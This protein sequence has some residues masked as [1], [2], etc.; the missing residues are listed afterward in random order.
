MTELYRPHWVVGDKKIYNQ[1]SANQLAF[2]DNGPAYKFCWLDDVYAKQSW[3]QEPTESW[4]EL[5]VER[6]RAIRQKWKK[7][8]LFFSA[9]RDSGHA[10][11]VF[12]QAGITIDELVL[13][14]SPHHP[15][16]LHEHNNIVLPIAKELCRRNPGMTIREIRQ[17]QAWYDRLWAKS[18]WFDSRATQR[19][20]LFTSY[21]WNELIETDPDYATGNCGYINGMEKPRIRVVDGNFVCQFLDTDIQFTALGLPCV[22]YFYWA[23]KLPKLFIKQ[24]WML[25]NHFEKQYPGCSPEFVE[26]FQ[27]VTSP[28]YDELC[29]A[30]GRGDPMHIAVGDG[31]NKIH[32]NY[33]WSMEQLIHT[34]TNEKWRGWKEYWL[35]LDDL[36]RNHSH[37]F[38]N[39]D[40]QLGTVGIWGEPYTI[41]KQ[42]VVHV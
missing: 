40:P 7:I 11:R 21:D 28:Y 16:R 12:E 23:P 31:R 42:D 8:K 38:N 9:G 17:D 41:K 22:E 35:M 27:K 18:D 14:Y 33:N 3:D 25:V 13:P 26:D 36:R 37:F 4:E 5:C 6:A 39:N 30:V 19:G 10:F 24:A 32:T 15:L 20:M 1:F 29:R 34:A 2:R